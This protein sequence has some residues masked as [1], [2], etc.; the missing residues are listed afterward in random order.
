MI[1]VKQDKSATDLRL[2]ARLQNGV[3][4]ALRLLAGC[5]A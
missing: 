3:K 4:A 1:P 5:R 2:L